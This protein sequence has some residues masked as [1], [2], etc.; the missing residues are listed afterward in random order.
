MSPSK[1]LDVPVVES[2]L[3][4][5][6]VTFWTIRKKI[7][8]DW[9]MIKPARQSWSQT[10]DLSLR[11]AA[12]LRRLETRSFWPK[13]LIE[14]KIILSLS[15]HTHGIAYQECGGIFTSTRLF[16]ILPCEPQFGNRR[17]VCMDSRRCLLPQKRVP[18]QYVTSKDDT[19]IAKTESDIQARDIK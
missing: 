14:C 19:T 3:W 15:G 8:C 16:S 10:A 7:H 12:A 1:I 11:R 2:I 5:R 4:S 6:G 9:W 13:A 18:V 17:H